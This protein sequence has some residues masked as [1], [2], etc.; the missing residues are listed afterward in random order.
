[1]SR[2]SPGGT[3]SR[4]RC[5]LNSGGLAPSWDAMIPVVLL[6]A[7]DLVPSLMRSIDGASRVSAAVDGVSQIVRRVSKR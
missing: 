6:P 3:A 4:G 2:P 1:V 5:R 7:A